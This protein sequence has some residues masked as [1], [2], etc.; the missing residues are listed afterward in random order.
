MND[1]KIGNQVQESTEEIKEKKKEKNEKRS[2]IILIILCLAIGI[3]TFVVTYK[4][5]NKDEKEEKENTVLSVNDQNVQILYNYVKFGTKGTRNDKFI[6]NKEVSSS[7]FTNQEKYY[8]A[9]QFVSSNDF[10]NTNEKEGESNIYFI[11]NKQI[12]EYM[13]KFFGPTVSYST[14]IELLYT[15]DFKIDNNNTAKLKYNSEKDGFNATFTNNEEEANSSGIKPFYT[16]LDSAVQTGDNSIII[17]EKVIYTEV[18]NN[19]DKYT[20][21]IYKDYSHGILIGT[22]ND[23]QEDELATR[24]INIDNYNS[25]SI[26]EYTFKNNNDSY[27]FSKSSIKM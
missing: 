21:N 10:E 23:L 9:L 2:V 27:Y 20:I 5:M 12:K 11:S 17:K 7:S 22:I 14:D 24:E 15:F 26:V 25:T 3:T 16:K 18:I 1:F 4:M 8:Y 19:N 6:K 13:Q